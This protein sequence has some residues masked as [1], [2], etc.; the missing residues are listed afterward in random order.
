MI[1][2]DYDT[3]TVDLEQT[4]QMCR[5]IWIYTCFSSKVT[6]NLMQRNFF[7]KTASF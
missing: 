7:R 5:L 2:S 1:I 4:E 3:N 6:D